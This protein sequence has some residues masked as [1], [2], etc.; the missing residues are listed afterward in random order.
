MIPIKD[1]TGEATSKAMMDIFNAHSS[2]EVILS[3]RG[4]ELWN[5]VRML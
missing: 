1:Q 5:K 4:C 3:D 2:P